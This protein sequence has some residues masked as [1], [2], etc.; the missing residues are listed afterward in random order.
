MW[1][2]TLRFIRECA[3]FSRRTE[4]NRDSPHTAISFVVY[5]SSTE[6]YKY[7]KE[8]EWQQKYIPLGLI[9]LAQ[10]RSPHVESTQGRPDDHDST[11]FQHR[12]RMSPWISLNA[13]SSSLFKAVLSKSRTDSYRLE[14]TKRDLWWLPKPK[15]IRYHQPL[16]RIVDNY[17][18]YNYTN[19]MEFPK[20]IR[21]LTM[22]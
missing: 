20:A 2:L 14:N 1:Y 10:L 3:N 5:L 8:V 12:R 13:F 7:N 6:W 21:H 19:T 15:S 4:K 17:D 22:L 16:Q 9:I 18:N 11:L